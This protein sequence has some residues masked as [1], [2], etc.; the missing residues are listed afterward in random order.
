MSKWRAP[1]TGSRPGRLLSWCLLWLVA[2]AALG[3]A[4]WHLFGHTPYR[5][6]IDVYQMG[7][8]AWLDGRPLYRGDVKFPTPIGLALPFT[9]PPLAAIMF[10]PF[11]WLHMPA[12]SVAVTLITLALLIVSTAIV[13]TGLDV[14][15]TSRMVPGPAWLRRLWFSV[16]IVAPATVW[17][18]P[19]I[20]NFAFGQINVVLMTLVIADCMPRRTPWPRG[21]LLGLGIALKLTPAVFLLYFLLRRD[22]RAALTALASF[23]AATLLGF[24]LAWSD[25]LEY[26]TH[27]V[28][29]T[30]RIGTASLNTDQNIVGALARLG[31]GEHQRFLLW[32]SGCL[33]VLAVT[34]WAMRRVLRAGEP[35]LAVICTA[36]FG[37][38][39]SPVSWS[40]HWVWM[41][42]AVLVTGILGW[43]RRD[44]AL[45]VVSAAGVALMRWTPIEL[46]PEHREATA[47]WWRQLAG[48][49]Y[50]WWALAVIVTAG[51]T[52][53]SRAT[54]HDSTMPERAP[55]SATT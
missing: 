30:D 45:A 24:I 27:T 29:H 47:V 35:V 37:L 1:G 46:L 18:E 26:W 34:I 22:R 21:L 39:V 28:L 52:V 49:S 42:P 17:L 44:L 41:L 5:I 2:G 23:A 43:R 48:M 55:V 8:Q 12:A 19:I 36:L 40:H 50:V 11:A 33:L 16:I 32:V 15:G 10:S 4:A 7:G 14:W 38:V 31:L 53:T 54:S 9:Y 25:A 13:L 20:S 51:L 3:W 6:D